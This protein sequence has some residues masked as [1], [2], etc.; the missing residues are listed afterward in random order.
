MALGPMQATP[1][2]AVVAVLRKARSTF[3]SFNSTLLRRSVGFS[4]GRVECFLELAFDF[5]TP[6][7]LLLHAGAKGVGML[8]G[9]PPFANSSSASLPSR[10]AKTSRHRCSPLGSLFSLLVT[11]LLPST[12]GSLTTCPQ[13]IHL[14]FSWDSDTREGIKSLLGFLTPFP[15]CPAR[16]LLIP[17]AAPSRS[18]QG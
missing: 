16:A 17:A 10:A 1:P 9:T 18:A 5:I 13:I 8:V 6:P 15:Q 3:T 2:P 4:N 14:Y 11:S 12:V 7:L